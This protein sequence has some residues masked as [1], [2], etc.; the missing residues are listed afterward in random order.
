MIA[1]G[2]LDLFAA[3][4]LVAI[5]FGVSPPVNMLITIPIL[6]TIKA[7]IGLASIGGIIDISAA[8]VISL[9]IFFT[10]P[11]IVLLIVMIAIGQKG[12]ASMFI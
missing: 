11:S 9:S 2:L 6:L 5:L 4:V 8:I 1:L 3:L 7:F 10:I 12:V